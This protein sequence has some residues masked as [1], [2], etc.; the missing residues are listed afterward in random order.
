MTPRDAEG[1]VVEGEV[2]DGATATGAGTARDVEQSA[3]LAR[4]LDDLV[5][6]PGT[7][8]GVGL[9]GLVGLIPGVGDSLTTA[10]AGGILADAFRR[11]VPVHVI[12]RMAGNLLVDTALG[13]IPL[14]GDAADFAHRA[15]R[16]N[17]GLLRDS[18]EKGDFST[19]P[20]PVYAA[21][22]LGVIGGVLLVMAASALFALWAVAKI[23]VHLLS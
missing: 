20:Y 8:I 5:T 9:D 7:T 19:D 22:A 4:V 2:L 14:V 15:N 21:K 23:L 18:I 3:L 11:R 10:L 13:Y 17:Y 6:I 16:K 1:E 12:V